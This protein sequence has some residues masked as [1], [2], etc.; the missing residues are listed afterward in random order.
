MIKILGYETS[1]TSDEITNDKERL[2]LIRDTVVFPIINRGLLWYMR[3]SEEQLEEL[4][5][6]YT[7]WLDA[8]ETGIIPE[9]PKWL[10]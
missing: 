7:A 3:L 5:E 6:W 1:L 4:D 10:E 9:T 8:P 2:R